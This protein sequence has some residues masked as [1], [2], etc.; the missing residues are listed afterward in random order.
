MESD[1][2]EIKTM[3]EVIIERDKIIELIKTS[4]SYIIMT[5]DEASDSIVSMANTSECDALKFFQI[6]KN[7]F[8]VAWVRFIILQAIEVSSLVGP[9]VNKEPI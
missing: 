3:E 8:P 7:N 4:K 9:V 2:K 6:M 5:Q 1:K